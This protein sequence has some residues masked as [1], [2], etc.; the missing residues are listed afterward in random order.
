MYGSLDAGN[1]YVSYHIDVMKT[2]VVVI[3]RRM[4]SQ[5]REMLEILYVVLHYLREPRAECML[6]VRIVGTRPQ[7]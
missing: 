1:R 6:I 4:E 3:T 7:N 5:P 2:W